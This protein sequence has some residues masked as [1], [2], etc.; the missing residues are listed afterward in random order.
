M[1]NVY[2]SLGW[3]PAPPVDFYQQVANAESCQAL[4]R[5]VKHALDDNQLRRISKKLKS[6]RERG[7]D[8]MQLPII[9]F[10][11]IGNSTTQLLE[12]T[13][14][15]SALRFG[16]LLDVIHAEF[17][18]LPQVAFSERDTFTVNPMDVVLVSVDHRSLPFVACPGDV[19]KAQSNLEDCLEYLMQI[20]DGIH[21]KNKSHVMLQNFAPLGEDIFGS[22]ERRLP[23]TLAWLINQLNTRLDLLNL[24]HVSIVDI[25]GLAANVGVANWHNQ[26]LWHLGKIPFAPKYNPIYGDWVMR[27]VAARLGRSRRCLILD[28]DNTLWGGTIGDDGLNGIIIGNGHATGEAHTAL[29]RTA[30]ALRERGVVL[31]VSSK[32]EDSVA[33]SPFKEHPDMLLREHHIAV[34]QANWQDKAS[35]IEA[36]ASALSL[37]LESMVFVDDNPAERMQVRVVLPS[38]AVP[39]L[40]EDPAFFSQTLLAAGYFEAVGF[41]GEDRI[42]A[43]FYQDNGKRIETL[44]K[45]SNLDDY[46]KSLDMEVNFAPFD[47]LGTPRISQLI[48]K[49][50]QFNLTTRR[51]SEAEIAELVL[52][53]EYFTLQVRLKDVHG[54]NGMIIVIICKKNR[55]HWNIDTWLMSCRVLGRRVEEAVLQ[56]ILKYARIANVDKLI[57]TYIP[58]ARNMIVRDHYAKLGF[59]KI[60]NNEEPDR[61]E[62]NTLE[63]P[64][65]SLPMRI[66]DS[67][68]LTI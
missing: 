28:L 47:K 49:S 15:G 44:K 33:R 24:M 35:N 11:I 64:E 9:K 46:L 37:G 41:S 52:N 36:I 45:S 27:L 31:A 19:V 7:A 66:T 55:S 39:E 29:Q 30:L 5:L 62:I 58:T 20:T 50:N 25:A 18:Q 65:L 63:H 12:P 10:G 59:T 61:W 53:P 54:D 48:N 6:L 8:S 13:L 38:V 26:T 4:V 42:R 32:N 14:V 57:G 60:P 23:G 17:N 3:L 51:Y 34:F 43:A 68:A 40:P 67:S 56:H 21:K 22:Y 1:A 2:E 16:I